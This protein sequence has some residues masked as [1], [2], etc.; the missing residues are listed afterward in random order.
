MVMGLR[1]MKR[2]VFISFIFPLNNHPFLALN[3][4]KYFDSI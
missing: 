2:S 3:H 1:P 4:F